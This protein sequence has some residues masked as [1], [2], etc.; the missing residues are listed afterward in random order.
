[1]LAA[2]QI[3]A[4]AGVA[5]TG[6]S[7]GAVSVI[8]ALVLAPVA[9]WAVAAAGSRVAGPRFGLAAAI[10]FVLLPH[11]ARAYFYG[12]YDKVYADDV[13]SNLMGLRATW[14]YALGVAAAIAFRFAPRA[15]VAAA[16]V[17][18][19]AVALAVWGTGELGGVK[20]NLHETGWSPGLLEWLPVAGAV[21]AA[22]KAPLLAV[23]LF[24]WLL[25][26]V[27]RAADAPYANGAFWRELVPA[28]PAAAL[29]VT[30]VSLL[31]PRVRID[32]R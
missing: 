1:V 13:L 26:V 30:A 14:T 17:V 28:L 8:A 21:G 24:G 15:V 12:A 3:A 7:D 23:G 20:A 10:V 4:V 11:V 31:V 6:T 29:L 25:F 5:V 2:V 22:R 9:V 16:G 19:A 18:A 27:L 32:V